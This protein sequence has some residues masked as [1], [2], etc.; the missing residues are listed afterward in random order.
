MSE[1]T[2]REGSDDTRDVVGQA[3]T[4]LSY[5]TQVRRALGGGTLTT[6]KADDGLGGSWRRVTLTPEP[7]LE[8]DLFACTYGDTSLGPTDDAI[9]MVGQSDSAASSLRKTRLI[10]GLYGLFP[11]AHPNGAEV[12]SL[13]GDVAIETGALAITI[14]RDIGTVE[15]GFRPGDTSHPSYAPTVEEKVGTSGVFQPVTKARIS[16]MDVEAGISRTVFSFSEPR[17]K[18]LNFQFPER[19]PFCSI[20][21]AHGVEGQE[22][23]GVA[24]VEAAYAWPGSVDADGKPFYRLVTTDTPKMALFRQGRAPMI[25]GFPT[26]GGV[27][28]DEAVDPGGSSTV[29]SINA[30]YAPLVTFTSKTNAV[31]LVV[32]GSRPDGSIEAPE[33]RM[34]WSEDAGKTWTPRTGPAWDMTLFNQKIYEIGADELRPPPNGNIAH[35]TMAILRYTF[36]VPWTQD[37]AVYCSLSLGRGNL[38][39]GGE[40]RL[41]L[42]G[43]DGLSLLPPVDA[44]GYQIRIT[45]ACRPVGAALFSYYARG[46]L[47]NMAL[48]VRSVPTGKLDSGE[49]DLG[50]IR[51]WVDGE[52]NPWPETLIDD[53]AGYF[54]A[55]GIIVVKE[56]GAVMRRP[57]PWPRINSGHQ[58]K[59]FCTDNDGKEIGTVAYSPGD[60]GW[61]LHTSRDL[62]ATWRRRTRITSRCPAPTVWPGY[63]VTGYVVPPPEQRFVFPTSSFNGTAYVLPSGVVPL[64]IAGAVARA[65]PGAPWLYK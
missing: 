1:F 64:R 14:R 5:M 13:P 52:P 34:Y 15:D 17:Y 49:E 31:A 40:W 2:R 47:A 26:D 16:K 57:F 37:S 33:P 59:V 6:D 29:L 7:D 48:E 12:V 43:A 4:G 23:W 30:Y 50:S 60:D 8:L 36:A 19:M 61:Y 58:P 65:Y 11:G 25:L 53:S 35:D 62:G 28:I 38:S 45:G 22:T 51:D 9:Y 41:F 63:G 44:Q 3:A 32:R 46:R 21:H 20:F 18:G 42:Q 55:A 54:D 24:Y 10:A 39:S 27:P 56:D